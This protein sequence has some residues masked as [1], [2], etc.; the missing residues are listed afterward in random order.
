VGGLVAWLLSDRSVPTSVDVLH[1][2]GATAA[3]DGG[4]PADANDSVQALLAA[5][6]PAELPRAAAADAPRVP[7]S[8]RRALGVLT[9]RVL[10]ADKQPCRT[11]RW[12]CWAG[13]ARSSPASAPSCRAA[14]T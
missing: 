11:C 7:E 2:S 12:S 14:S 4:Q 1:S 13:G 8:Y 3:P 6:T 9:G 5:T 10:T